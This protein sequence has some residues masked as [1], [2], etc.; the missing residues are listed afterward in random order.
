MARAIRRGNDYAKG[1]FHQL[2][3]KS[4]VHSDR[5]FKIIIDLFKISDPPNGYNDNIVSLIWDSLNCAREHIFTEW[6]NFEDATLAFKEIKKTC[7]HAIDIFGFNFQELKGFKRLVNCKN[8][9]PWF[10]ALETDDIAGDYILPSGLI[11]DTF[12]ECGKSFIVWNNKQFLSIKTCLGMRYVGENRLIYFD[13]GSVWDENYYS[14][15]HLPSPRPITEKELWIEEAV[16]QFR[17]FLSGK[18]KEFT[19]NFIDGNKFVGKLFR[20][21]HKTACSEGDYYISV[22]IAGKKKQKKGWVNFVPSE[23]SP[24]VISEVVNEFAKL[25]QTVTH[26]EIIA[27]NIKKGGKKWKGV[28]FNRQEPS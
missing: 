1:V 20:G 22:V 13:D 18:N 26:V 28:F 23:E 9:H 27:S 19:I 11:S 7:S 21:K 16:Q 17:S 25:S 10:F 14:S 4:H 15:R 6:E 5:Y 3:S 2:C 12:Y 8:L 24:N